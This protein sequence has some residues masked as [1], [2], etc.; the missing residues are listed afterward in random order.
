MLGRRQRLGLSVTAGWWQEEKKDEERE[1][2]PGSQSSLKR[3][4]EDCRGESEMPGYLMF[5][6]SR[7][8]KDKAGETL[9][10]FT[11]EVTE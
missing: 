7:S 8:E 5:V 1:E 9:P 10:F 4:K 6:G 11:V 3:T 2:E